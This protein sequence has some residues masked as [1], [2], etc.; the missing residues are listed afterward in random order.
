MQAINDTTISLLVLAF[1]RLF[2][3]CIFIEMFFRER[4]IHY[5]IISAGWFFY[6]LGPCIAIFF[7]HF[8]YNINHPL[9]GYSIAI[10]TF[11][12]ILGINYMNFNLFF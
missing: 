4:K 7:Y 10:G 3:F 6:A 9:F 8:T 2:A 11:L 5:A 12:I 1:I